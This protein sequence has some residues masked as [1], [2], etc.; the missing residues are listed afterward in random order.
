MRQSR[1]ARRESQTGDSPWERTDN[2][3]ILVAGQRKW[4]GRPR[5]N[6]GLGHCVISKSAVHRLRQMPQQAWVLRRRGPY[7]TKL[8]ESTKAP[9]RTVPDRTVPQTGSGQSPNV[10]DA[11]VTLSSQSPNFTKRSIRDNRVWSEPGR[12]MSCRRWSSFLT[13]GPSRRY[14]P[15]GGQLVNVTGILKTGRY[16]L[17]V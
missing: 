15:T 8:S 1:A 2:E 4:L 13:V 9:R 12:L 5:P 3:G 17:F 11:T 7:G 6:T 16:L 10:G 14:R